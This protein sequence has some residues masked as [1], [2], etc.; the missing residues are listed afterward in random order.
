MKVQELFKNLEGYNNFAKMCGEN[1]REIKCYVQFG[2]AYQ[3][4]NYKEFEKQIR[5]EYTDD[6]ANELLEL[7][8][9][10]GE[11]YKVHGDGVDF[12]YVEKMTV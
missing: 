12:Y 6:F 2:G 10:L 11:T 7:D 1:E 3:A 8:V 9:E 5:D 4:G